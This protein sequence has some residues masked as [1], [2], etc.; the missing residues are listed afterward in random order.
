MAMPSFWTV[1]LLVGSSTRLDCHP[2]IRITG[3]GGS[4]VDAGRALCY[5]TLFL[6]HPGLIPCCG[7]RRRHALDCTQPRR[8]G[9]QTL[10]LIQGAGQKRFDVPDI[11]I[12]SVRPQGGPMEDNGNSLIEMPYRAMSPEQLERYMNLLGVQRRKPS[13]EALSELVQA[14]LIRIP[15]ENLSKLYYKKHQNLRDLPSLEQF[16][17]GI[18]RFHFGGTCYSNNY[19]LYQLLANLGYQIKLCGADMSNPDV[20][21]I[22]MVTVEKREYLVDV[23]YAAPF[24]MPLPRDM[25]TDYVIELG[26]DRYVL[27]PQ[28]AKGRS[29]MELYRD[30]SLKHGYLAKPMP[31]RIHEFEHAIADS[32]LKDA[33]FMNA[34]LLVRFSPN[35]SLAVHNLTVIESQ[36]SSSSLRTL[37]SQDELVQ[38]VFEDFGIPGEFTMDVLNELGRLQDAWV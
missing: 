10:R 17:D 33:T 18:H 15:F 11:R 22:S 13:V 23:G 27:K 26:Q 35:R 12:L 20:H 31:R 8:V 5:R 4:L 6:R 19:Y 1:G 3:A 7:T 25:T 14:H 2:R 38:V 30:G 32:Y 34:L 29:R 37:A 36:G 21:M 16:L 24:L 9:L 28:D